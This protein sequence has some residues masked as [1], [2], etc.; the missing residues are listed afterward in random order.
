MAKGKGLTGEVRVDPR[1]RLAV[2]LAWIAL[3]SLLTLAFVG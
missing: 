1:R 2:V 3:V